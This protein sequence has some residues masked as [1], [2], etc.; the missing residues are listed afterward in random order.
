[1]WGSVAKSSV[2][3]GGWWDDRDKV[4]IHVEQQMFFKGM[5]LHILFLINL[6]FNKKF[7]IVLFNLLEY[8][9]VAKQRRI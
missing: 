9:P 2:Y 1:M 7:L 4:V 3:I 8:F 5:I 6:I